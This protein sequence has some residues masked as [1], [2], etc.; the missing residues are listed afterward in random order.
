[1]KSKST[2]SVVWPTGRWGSWK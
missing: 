1:M 2:N